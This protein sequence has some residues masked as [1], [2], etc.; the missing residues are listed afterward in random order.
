MVVEAA[1]GWPLRLLLDV[2]PMG[3]LP[4]AFAL[5]FTTSR[6]DDDATLLCEAATEDPADCSAIG[7]TGR[8]NAAYREL[9]EEPPSREPVS[10]PTEDCE[11]RRRA[12]SGRRFDADEE[13]TN[14][15]V[16]PGDFF[17]SALAGERL[18]VCFISSPV[19]AVLPDDPSSL[20]L[21]ASST[22][23]SIFSSSESWGDTNRAVGRGPDAV[24]P[25]DFFK[26]GC[27]GGG[28]DADDEKFFAAASLAFF[29]GDDSRSRRS[30]ASSAVGSPAGPICPVW[31]KLVSE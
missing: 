28:L 22:A 8:G 24:G 7:G 26:M 17:L 15:F 30:T 13:A 23:C 19:V 11:L 27:R 31:P 10:E 2:A 1:G 3:R 4:A 14:F 25:L 5:S 6:R 9:T 12:I 18:D 16:V 20:S 21:V 29:V